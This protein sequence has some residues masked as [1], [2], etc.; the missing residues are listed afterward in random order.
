VQPILVEEKPTYQSVPATT[1]F[2]ENEKIELQNKTTF[3]GAKSNNSSLSPDTRGNS[4]IDSKPKGLF[5]AGAKKDKKNVFNPF[6]KKTSPSPSIS[7][8]V[9]PPAPKSL[10]L[11]FGENKNTSN[12]FESKLKPVNLNNTSS[13]ISQAK[14]DKSDDGISEQISDNYDED[15]EVASAGKS[16]KKAND[17]FKEEQKKKEK[18][19][20][21]SQNSGLGFNDDYE[22]TDFF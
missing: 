8:I 20:D 13:M 21:P 5:G 16:G 2:G 6:A 19:S 14:K 18:Q 17:F 4:A 3:G 22:D 1:A 10:G 11:S 9:D 15:F 7:K 12:D